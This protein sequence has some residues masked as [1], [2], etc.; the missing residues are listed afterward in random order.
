MKNELSKQQIEDILKILDGLVAQG[1]WNSSTF[2]RVIAKK[3]QAIRDDFATKAALHNVQNTQV[4]SNLANR[5]AI[6]SGQQEVF[7]ALYTADGA[8]IQAW[9]RIIAN[10]PK[11]MI[12]RPIYANEE[13]VNQVIRSKEN[14]INEAYISIYVNQTDVLPMGD[15]TPMDKFGK[16]LLTLK[17][18]SLQ[19]EHITRFVHVSGIYSYEGGRLIK[20]VHQEQ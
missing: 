15:K 17:D 18:R 9:E 14:K 8:N 1:G 6:R 16:S 20:E 5:V 11:Q 12:S 7:I 3:L 4:A 2:L 10:L 19:L 13:D